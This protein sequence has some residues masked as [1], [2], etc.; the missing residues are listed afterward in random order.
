MNGFSF[1][2]EGQ[3]VT[4]PRFMAVYGERAD[5]GDNSIPRFMT[6]VHQSDFEEAQ[7]CLDYDGVAAE[8]EII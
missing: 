6:A 8:L 1:Y 5:A 2:I 4:Y 3:Q 7:D